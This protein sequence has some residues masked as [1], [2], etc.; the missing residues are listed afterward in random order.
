MYSNADLERMMEKNAEEKREVHTEEVKT[1]VRRTVMNTKVP[2]HGIWRKD[3]K[4]VKDVTFLGVNI[5]S[6]S[7]WSKNS[8]KAARLRHIIQEYGV[9]SVGLQEVCVNWEKLPPSK[10]LAESLREKVE[11]IR[12]IAS[13]N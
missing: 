3:E 13:H 5:N 12:S 1:K 7:H 9:D 8:N 11:S 4:E 2:T 6:L 10:S